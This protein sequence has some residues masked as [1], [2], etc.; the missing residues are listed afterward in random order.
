LSGE[1]VYES[2]QT[3]DLGAQD[4]THKL[5]ERSAIVVPTLHLNNPNETCG[6]D[7]GRMRGMQ[8]SSIFVPPDV[9]FLS[10]SPGANNIARLMPLKLWLF[11][12]SPIRYLDRNG[13]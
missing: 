7:K 6:F 5:P 3:P 8:V 4:T 1:V 9:G 13:N 11:E 2:P 10:Y 12:C